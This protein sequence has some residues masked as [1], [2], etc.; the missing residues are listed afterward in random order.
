MMI[1]RDR[2][3]IRRGVVLP[4]VAVCLIALIGLVA[5]AID[6]G[7]VAVAKTQSQSAADSIATVGARSMNGSAANNYANFDGKAVAKPAIDAGTKNTIFGQKI[8]GD[9]TAITADANGYTFSSG[10][11][12]VDM[13]AFVYV[14]DDTGKTTEGFVM[15]FP[16]TTTTEPYDA[17]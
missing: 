6:I 16:K 8:P 5:L 14:Y 10:S 15:Q 3:Q 2:R 9:P 17:V 12:S 7:M 4:L 1:R 13:G 11:I